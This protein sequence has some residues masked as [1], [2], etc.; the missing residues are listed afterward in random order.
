MFAKNEL[1]KEI[2]L[3]HQLKKAIDLFQH[4]QEREAAK[5]FKA[6]LVIDKN[7]LA[8]LDYLNRINKTSGAITSLEEIQKNK[9]IWKLY[10]DGLRFMR[11]KEYQKAIDS[12]NQ[13]L[14]KFPNSVETKNNIKQAQ[15][16]LKAEQ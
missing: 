7:N 11:E 1:G 15:L 16:R 8:A 9:K 14:G 5:R 12:W 6:I 10:I 13:V 2:N 3:A 4:G